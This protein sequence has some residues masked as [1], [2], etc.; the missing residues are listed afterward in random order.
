LLDSVKEARRSLSTTFQFFNHTPSITISHWD[1]AH[2]LFSISL[3]DA[4]V[5]I[6]DLYHQPDATT[7]ATCSPWTVANLSTSSERRTIKRHYQ[8]DKQEHPQ[9]LQTVSRSKA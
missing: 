8:E 5:F 9:L 2:W 1:L 4:L 7:W 6:A 3:V